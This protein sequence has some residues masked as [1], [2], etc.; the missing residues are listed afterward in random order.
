MAKRPTAG[1]PLPRRAADTPSVTPPICGHL[2]DRGDRPYVCAKNPG[3][4]GGHT[5]TR[6][7][8]EIVRKLAE[9]STS[10][11]EGGFFDVPESPTDVAAMQ[12]PS[13]PVRAEGEYYAGHGIEAFGPEPDAPR[14][15]RTAT[16]DGASWPGDP[17]EQTLVVGNPDAL[18]AVSPPGGGQAA[19]P[20][21]A[22]PSAGIRSDLPAGVTAPAGSGGGGSGRSLARR[23]DDTEAAEEMVRAAMSVISQPAQADHAIRHSLELARVLKLAETAGSMFADLASGDLVSEGDIRVVRDLA[24]R[25]AATRGVEP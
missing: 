15:P 8:G 20:T 17:D 14:D 6:A 21:P 5:M 2:E 11:P 25:M 16:E 23:A 9:R 19:D 1:G 7:D 4:L 13:D 18:P 12:T 24:W 3:H 22:P 10:V